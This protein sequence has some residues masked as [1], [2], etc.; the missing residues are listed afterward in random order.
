MYSEQSLKDKLKNKANKL[1]IPVNS[2]LI[3]YVFEC[4]L[5]RI[6]KS[7]WSRNIVLKGGT[8]IC[9]LYG[10]EN[11]VTKDIDFS[12]INETLEEK[13]IKQI[14]ED[15][16]NM[17][18]KDGIT[19]SLLDIE[20]IMDQDN[21]GGLRAKIGYKFDKIKGSISIDIATGDIITPNPINYSYKSIL[22]D[23]SFN[24]LAYNPETIIA[25]K[26]ESIL[27]LGVTNSRMKDYYDLYI[28]SKYRRRIK[29]DVKILKSAIANTFNTRNYKYDNNTFES[30]KNSKELQQLWK[31]YSTNKEFVNDITYEDVIKEI[32]Q[33]INLI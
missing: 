4:I 20:P 32:D 21:Y 15:I 10:L 17:D 9:S 19:L 24:I 13:T 14:A 7:E 2:V 31:N 11:R 27:E 29:I 8:L 5:K 22:D 1:E 3:M 6:S 12:L 18:L 25:E 26:L 30:I 28:T 16:I 23:E 33:Y